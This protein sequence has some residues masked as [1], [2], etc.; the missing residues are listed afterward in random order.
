MITQPISE[1]SRHV[2]DTDDKV[3]IT[4]ASG[5]LGEYLC[6]RLQHQS[7]SYLSIER[8]LRLLTNSTDTCIVGDLSKAPLNL[9]VVNVDRVIHLAGVAHYYPK[10]VIEKEEI[11]Q[12][13]IDITSNL[14]ETIEINKLTPR[15]IVFVSTVAVYGVESGTNIPEDF[16]ANPITPYGKAKFESEKLLTDWCNDH[17]VSLFIVR[18]GLIVGE[19]PKGNLESLEKMIK[20][21]IYIGIKGNNARKSLVHALDLCDLMV[22]GDK[23]SGVYNITDGI[24]HGF[25]SVEL[26]YAKKLNK[27]IL[28]T[29]PKYVFSMASKIG[30]VLSILN[31]GFIT[32]TN[33]L[34]KMCNPLTF[35]NEKISDD[36]N[37]WKPEDSLK[38][39]CDETLR[40][41]T[42]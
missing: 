3:L 5:F 36:A 24:Q 7:L 32:D 29:L 1:S 21:G 13:N 2:L 41:D 33:R 15:Q 14:I 35:S 30:D 17:N 9:P 19:N 38:K 16:P 20:K 27:R 31:I 25:N 12:A 34:A 28:M 18:P 11:Y 37:W 22:K 39:M 4:G 6:R 26:A 42:G 40:K 23:I 8:N 10:N